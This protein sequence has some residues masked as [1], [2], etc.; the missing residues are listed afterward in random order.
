MSVKFRELVRLVR[1]VEDVKGY[2]T[3]VYRLKAKLLK[4]CYGI[5]VK[6]V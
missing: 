4:A 6:E 3:Q 1:V 5:I 2:R